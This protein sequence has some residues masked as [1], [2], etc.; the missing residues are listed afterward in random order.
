[1][2]AVVAASGSL[3][4]DEFRGDRGVGVLRPGGPG[5]LLPGDDPGV[6]D[7]SASTPPAAR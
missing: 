2:L 1:M 6:N 4:R 5:Q 3:S 7:P